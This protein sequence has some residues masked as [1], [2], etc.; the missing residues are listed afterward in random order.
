MESRV[1]ETLFVR[2]CDVK[3]YTSCIGS[4]VHPLKGRILFATQDIHRDAVIAHLLLDD[5]KLVLLPGID[6]F[7]QYLE[8]KSQA[9]ARKCIEHC[10]PTGKGQILVPN[11]MHW[12][13]FF[14]YSISHKRCD[15]MALA[16]LFA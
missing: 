1:C 9:D 2:S 14:N 7:T 5:I 6:A 11:P 8:S 15:K 12:N 13:N 10:V 3:H 16:A 4:V